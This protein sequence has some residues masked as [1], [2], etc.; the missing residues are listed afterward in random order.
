MEARGKFTYHRNK[1]PSKEVTEAAEIVTR[2]LPQVFQYFR[3][4]DVVE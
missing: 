4:L 3:N 1:L 2:Y